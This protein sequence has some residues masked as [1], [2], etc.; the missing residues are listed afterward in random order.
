MLAATAHA[1]DPVRAPAVGADSVRTD[2]QFAVGDRFTFRYLDL[3]SGVEGGRHKLKVTAL[4]ANEVTFNGGRH[5]TDRLG[6]DIKSGKEVETAGMQIFIPEYS[7]GRKWST[8]FRT[9]KQN[10][11][12]NLFNYD[13][14]VVAKERITVPAGTFDTYRVEGGGY[15]RL[16][17]GNRRHKSDHVAAFKIWIAPD[18]VFKY[19]AEEYILQG[20]A[21]GVGY[22]KVLRYELV[23]FH[24]AGQ[25]DAGDDAQADDAQLEPPD[26][27]SYEEAPEQSGG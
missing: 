16:I 20:T 11:E 8:E 5:V 13:F 2:T 25:G 24:R 1:A 19:V 14:T 3:F 18:K 6:N 4:S 27:S 12:E 21:V 22:S 10:G 15:V 26:H 17:R 7:V 23:A 9:R